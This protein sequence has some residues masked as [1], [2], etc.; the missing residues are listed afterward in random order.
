[1]KLEM[2]MELKKEMQPRLKILQSEV[3]RSHIATSINTAR[4]LQMGKP[5]IRLTIT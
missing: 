1:M 3:Q 2:I 5:I 4:F